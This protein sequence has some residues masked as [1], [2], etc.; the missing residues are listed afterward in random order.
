MSDPVEPSPVTP[1]LLRDWSLPAAD[2]DKY[3]RG[4]VLVTGGARRSPGAAQLAGLSALRVEAGRLTLAVVESVAVALAVATPEAGVIGVPEN[5]AGAVL[6][7]AAELLGS[8]IDR[9]DAILIG[10]GLDDAELTGQ[11]LDALRPALAGTTAPV[12][13][14]ASPSVCWQSGASS[15]TPWP[16]ASPSPRTPVRLPGWPGRTRSEPVA[17]WSTWPVGTAPRSACRAGQRTPPGC[18]GSPPGTAG[19]APPGA[20]MSWRERSSVCSRGAPSLCKRPAGAPISMR[21]P[22]ID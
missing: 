12:L 18:G 14:D 17:T 7:D 20:A 3:G 9:A 6:P 16:A 8:E 21:W 22:A 4:Q 1:A 5:A 19:W 2:G 15:W 11:L 13:L 10:A